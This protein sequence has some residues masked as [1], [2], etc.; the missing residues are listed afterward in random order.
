MINPVVASCCARLA[1]YPNLTVSLPSTPGYTSVQNSF[2]SLQEAS[3][4]PTCIISP[5][6]SVLAAKAIQILVSDTACTN[7]DFALK[8]QGHAPAAGFGNIDSTGVTIDL[9][10]LNSVTLSHDRTVAHIGA[11]ASWLQAYAALDP[12]NVTVAGGRN[13]A[14]GVA[15]LTLG[16]GISYFSPLVGFTCDTAVEFEVVLAN[17]VLTH[18]NRRNHPELF[19]ALKGGMNNFG[20]VTRISLRTIPYSG[21]LAG[22]L[23]YEID[24]RGR[25]F[26]AFANIAGAAEYDNH[27]S[28]VTGVT[29]NSTAK[30]WALSNTP[31]YTKPD[32]KPKVYE[33]L[34]RIPTQLNTLHITNMSTYANETPTPPLNWLFYTATFGVSA[35]LLNTIFDTINQT[36]YDFTLPNGLLWNLAFE[37][38]PTTFVDRGA[39]HNS[40]GTSAIDGNSVILL[41]SA[42]WPAENSTNE[43][44]EAQM[45]VHAHAQVLVSKINQAARHAGLARDF[46]YANYADASQNPLGGYGQGNLMRLDMAAEAYDPHGVFRKRVPGGFK[47]K[48]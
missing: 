31:V 19:R 45:A 1:T 48:P 11:G 34:F 42:L 5:T 30:S 37:P 47:L 15:G 16:G 38:L 28:I 2:W 9:T 14:V 35:E 43:K 44:S 27:A 39:G 13:G 32:R 8:G 10:P 29:F 24:Q 36:L 25:V 40:L 23:A 4:T 46:L 41:I 18:A 21:I 20:V 26:Q 22:G 7:V 12:Y 33:E 3:L 6:T 17:G